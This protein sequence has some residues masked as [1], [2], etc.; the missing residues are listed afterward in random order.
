MSP[1]HTPVRIPSPE[2]LTP[3]L[4]ASDVERN[5]KDA[6]SII[7]RLRKY[8]KE[9]FPN[10]DV[11][12]STILRMFFSHQICRRWQQIQKSFRNIDSGNKGT[13]DFEQ[14][15]GWCHPSRSHCTKNAFIFYVTIIC[16]V[17]SNNYLQSVWHRK[18]FILNPFTLKSDQD[19]ISNTSLQYQAGKWWE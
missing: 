13:V 15:K 9:L 2:S 3:P 18:R 4:S 19:R 16:S 1:V 7:V 14:L 11:T 8:V 12:K 17:K 10:L 5:I 6:V